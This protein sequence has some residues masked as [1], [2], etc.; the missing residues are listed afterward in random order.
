MLW[1]YSKSK[2]IHKSCFIKYVTFM[3]RPTHTW[4]QFSSF[5]C[6]SFVVSESYNQQLNELNYFFYY[7]PGYARLQLLLGCA[8][9]LNIEIKE[10][11][12]MR[13]QF[14]M[15]QDGKK[16]MVH[17]FNDAER[18]RTSDIKKNCPTSEFKR[19]YTVHIFF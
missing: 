11:C 19:I 3:N 18:F 5:G 12:P 1:Y 4:W 14:L 17:V 10:M 13:S 8:R 7:K 6:R 2:E 16:Y 15:I 9:L